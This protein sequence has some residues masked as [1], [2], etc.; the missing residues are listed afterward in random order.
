MERQPYTLHHAGLPGNSLAAKLLR[1]ILVVALLVLGFTVSLVAFA[2]L[3][4]LALVF[5]VYFWWKTRSIRQQ[6]QAE[7]FAGAPFSRQ[8]GGR[9]I[10][11][12]LIHVEEE[13]LR[14]ADCPPK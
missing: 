1:L 2:V 8:G 4:V 11:G 7:G 12:E 6:M 13:P 10:E 3:A 14:Q 9:V 5:G